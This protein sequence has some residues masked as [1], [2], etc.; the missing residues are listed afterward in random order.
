MKPH[1]NHYSQ[2]NARSSHISSQRQL[3]PFQQ[4]VFSSTILQFQP[5]FFIQYKLL[6]TGYL[7]FLSISLCYCIQSF[8]HFIPI[9]NMDQWYQ[10]GLLFICFSLCMSPTRSGYKKLGLEPVEPFQD[11]SHRARPQLM[12]DENK[13]DEAGYPFKLLL[14]EA[15]TQQRNKMMDKFAQILRRLPT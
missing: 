13:Y 12:G 9:I 10:R 4:V 3:P 1:C 5:I 6:F 2:M 11:Q 15:L 7:L 8:I 14:E